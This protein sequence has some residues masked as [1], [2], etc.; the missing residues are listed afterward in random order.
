[1]PPELT[2]ILPIPLSDF[3]L[4]S[5]NA[6]TGKKVAP[7]ASNIGLTFATPVAFINVNEVIDPTVRVSKESVSIIFV[8]RFCDATIVEGKP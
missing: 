4:L 3:T 6:G 8:F 5:G 1:M 7:F 2:R